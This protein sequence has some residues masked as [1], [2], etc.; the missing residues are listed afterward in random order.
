MY[1]VLTVDVERLGLLAL[2]D[3]VADLALD[4]GTVLA[5]VDAVESQQR[6]VVPGHDGV[7]QEPPQTKTSQ[8]HFFRQH[9]SPF[10][11]TC[12]TSA[13]GSHEPRS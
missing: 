10:D 9:S 12:R 3:G 6:P 2:A 5:P 8:L 7:G 13:W 11:F 1:Y 4:D